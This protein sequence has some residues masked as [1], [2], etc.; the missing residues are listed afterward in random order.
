MNT[1]KA[2]LNFHARHWCMRLPAIFLFAFVSFF[3]LKMVGK[4][5]WFESSYTPR[6]IVLLCTMV[7]CVLNAENN[8]VKNIGMAEG[9][10]NLSKCLSIR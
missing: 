4:K 6:M 8:I 5:L 7:V 9:E 1:G 3:I 10:W 2:L